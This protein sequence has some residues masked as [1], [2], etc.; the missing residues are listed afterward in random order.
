MRISFFVFN[1]MLRM[2]GPKSDGRPSFEDDED[3]VAVDFSNAILYIGALQTITAVVLTSLVGILSC[4]SIP[5]NMVSAVR[6]LVLSSIVGILIVRKPF[7]LGRVHGL[8]LV[9]RALQPCVVIYISSQVAEQLVHT[10]TRDSS[11]PS[12]RRLVF[13]SMTAVMIVSGFMRAR[14]PLAST[15]LPFLLTTLALFVVALL[16]PP[17]VVLQGPLCSA[18]TLT[19][20]AERLVRAFVFSLLY[21][22]FVYS[23]APP[24]QS[25]SET[26]ICV[27]RA[28][29]ASIWVLA[30]HAGLL[31]L[32]LVQGVI[33]VYI[34]IFGAE[35]AL[36]D[37]EA[38]PLLPDRYD[39]EATA[40]AESP[41]RELES[42]VP[43]SAA[44]ESP[45]ASKN[46]LIVPEFSALGPRGLVDIG[47]SGVCGFGVSNGLGTVTGASSNGF[48]GLDVAA[49]AARLEN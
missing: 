5:L 18:P 9:F 19:S 28:S 13:H 24:V 46:G 45:D 26:I 25:S 6:T 12:W 32:A 35:Y 30:A 40:V 48:E 16:P 38:R 31:P 49:I 14:R 8:S 10:C 42:I 37:D 43:T 23:A 21:C 4:L 27:M 29:A 15:D 1:P 33:V 36:E 17:A 22:V 3:D 47:G 39:V 44:Q 20:A 34:R 41:T 11:A 2:R 7:R